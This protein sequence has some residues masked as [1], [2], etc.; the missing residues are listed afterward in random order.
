MA[1]P[2]LTDPR[3]VI[4]ILKRPLTTAELD[5]VDVLS[6]SVVGT[7][8]LHLNRWLY[9]RAVV[10]EKHRTGTQGR[11]ILYHEPVAWIDALHYDTSTA[12]SVA[13]PADGVW[14]EPGAFPARRTVWVDYTTGDPFPDV[15]W[16]GAA[17][18][19]VANVVA[20]TLALPGQ[21]ATGALKSYSVEGT[22]ITYAG[23]DAPGSKGRLTVGDLGV[24]ARLRVPVVL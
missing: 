5:R 14:E 4:G 1:N 17:S 12:A 21:V 3:A 23:P 9:R 13:F 7:L 2:L 6:D 24:L 15:G 16:A 22:S 10:G 11:I 8:E 20:R 18:D 19:V